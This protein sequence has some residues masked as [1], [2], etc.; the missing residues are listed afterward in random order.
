MPNC[1]ISAIW[2]GDNT[3]S[4][5]SL[6]RCDEK[7]SVIGVLRSG[8]TCPRSS[9]D[10][11]LAVNPN[12]NPNP[13]LIYSAKR[14]A[15]RWLAIKMLAS[16][17]LEVDTFL[18]VVVPHS[19]C[20]SA[21]RFTV[22]S[23]LFVVYCR[24]SVVYLGGPVRRHWVFCSFCLWFRNRH[25]CQVEVLRKCYISCATMPRWNVMPRKWCGS[26]QTTVELLPRCLRLPYYSR[27]H[28]PP[29]PQIHN[30]HL[31]C[32]LQYRF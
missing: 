17:N 11:V 25:C 20:Q 19:L 6:A 9:I 1:T 2:I 15:R 23:V 8:S 4:S 32:C 14:M 24:C 13:T 29:P 30:M 27:A 7:Q 18:A 16:F 3:G 12:P 28:I 10:L 21:A 26:G 22:A 31:P 5:K